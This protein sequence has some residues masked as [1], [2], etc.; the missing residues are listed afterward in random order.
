MEDRFT[1]EIYTDDVQEH[2]WRVV[3]A[4]GRTV[5]ASS[6]GYKNR[7]YCEEIATALHRGLELVD[8]DQ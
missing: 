3:S 5:A 6:E 2:R 1:V 8:V 7:Q 4:N